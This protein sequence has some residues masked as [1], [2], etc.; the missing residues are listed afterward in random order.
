MHPELKLVLVGLSHRT[1]PVRVREQYVV[2]QEDQT[3]CVRSLM[4]E[5]GIE[6]AAVVSTCNRT[7]VLVCGGKDVEMASCVMQRVF[8]NLPPEHAYVY[9]DVHAVI[10]T[11]RVASGLDSVV[12]G[13]SEILG[14]VK[15][16]YEVGL[17]EGTLGALLEPL[18]QQALQVGKR[19]RNETSVG[20]GSLSVARV[21]V[22]IAARVVGSF[23]KRRALVVGAGETGVLVGQHLRSRGLGTLVL[24]N[25]TLSRAQEAA[26]ELS[27]EAHGL[28]EVP[29]LIK[30]A[31]LVFTCIEGGDFELDKGFFDVKRLARR[32]RPLFVADL[33]VPRAVAP[34]VRDLNQLLLYDLDDLGHVVESN[35]K[36]R[37]EAAD[38]SAEILVAE[39]HK[40]LSLRTYASFTP[41]IA[42][43]R[44]RFEETRDAVL[45]RIA[46]ANAKPEELELSHV[47][48]KRLLDV[49]LAQ[50]KDS[51][52]HTRSERLV[53]REYQRFLENL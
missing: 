3:D 45:D 29:A 1:A 42:R 44:E 8:R 4:Q 38:D 39:I 14:Q 48:T 20:L 13:E 15:R 28:D 35:R 40:Y 31:D 10:H 12:L 52:R 21:A 41:A 19:I 30:E 46:G 53:D 9:E 25:R 5:P 17:Q 22:D 34:E 18:L 26:G 2:S 50:M 6:E 32:D 37:N 7:E 33:S 11:F 23:E 36:Q 43:L 49:A 47:L 51:A 24:A 16:A 27:A